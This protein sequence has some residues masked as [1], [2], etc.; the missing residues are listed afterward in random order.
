MTCFLIYFFI[1]SH[2]C[3][4][5]FLKV[6]FMTDDS[7]NKKA[8]KKYVFGLRFENRILL[9][10]RQQQTC[11]C[12]YSVYTGRKRKINTLFI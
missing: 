12:Q 3:P 4:T 8:V 5:S 1:L 11:T 9:I 6:Q 10:F 2:V 7:G